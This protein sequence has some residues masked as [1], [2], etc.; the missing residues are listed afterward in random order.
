MAKRVMPSSF[1][2]DCGHQSD[3]FENTVREVEASSRRGRKW[4]E[5]LDSEANEHG[6]E[7]RDGR[8]T[9]VNCPQLGRSE[10]TGWA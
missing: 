5:L 8:A 3:F 2:C 4:V 7:F 1:R 9:A 10:I 6:I